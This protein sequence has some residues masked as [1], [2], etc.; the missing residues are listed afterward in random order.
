[1]DLIVSLLNL[2]LEYSHLNISGKTINLHWY[3]TKPYFIYKYMSTLTKMQYFGFNIKIISFL[4]IKMESKSSL[5]FDTVYESLWVIHT[6]SRQIF[7]AAFYSPG[8]LLTC[9][10]TQVELRCVYKSKNNTV[11]S[12][13][14]GTLIILRYLH[15]PER[16]HLLVLGEKTLKGSCWTCKICLKHFSLK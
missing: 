7:W 15:S 4:H 10:L 2:H 5:E 14:Y 16:I 6:K 13:V 9:S 11:P 3:I 8:E 12:I 1:M